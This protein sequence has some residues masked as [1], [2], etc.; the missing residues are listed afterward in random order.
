MAHRQGSYTLLTT[1]DRETHRLC[2]AGAAV[3]NLCNGSSRA[4]W[5]FIV[6]VGVGLEDAAVF[7]DM[8]GR[9]RAAAVAQ[10]EE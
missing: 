6:S 4:T 9:V 7:G 10:V 1:L 3:L 8:P 5:L 2:R